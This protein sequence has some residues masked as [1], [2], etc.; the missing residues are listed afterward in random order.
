MPTGDQAGP[1]G[2]P[3]K[4]LNFMEQKQERNTAQAQGWVG[5][6][7]GDEDEDEECDKEHNMVD[8]KDACVKSNNMVVRENR[9]I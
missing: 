5:G 6:G 3:P 1:D 8:Q 2:T 9:K 4:A 7:V